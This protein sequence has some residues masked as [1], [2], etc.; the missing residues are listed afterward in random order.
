MAGS[1]TAA[2]VMVVAVAVQASVPLLQEVVAKNSRIPKTAVVFGEQLI[3]LIVGFILSGRQCLQP[4]QYLAFLPSAV[5]YLIANICTFHAVN[6]LGA[7]QFTLLVQLCLISTAVFQRVL[8]GRRRTPLEWL[9][10]FQL[11]LAMC[12]FMHLNQPSDDRGGTKQH[13]ASD[14]APRD[15]V[16]GLLYMAVVIPS[17][18][19]ASVCMEMQLKRKAATPFAAQMHQN[20]F[21]QALFAFSFAA[22]EGLGMAFANCSV[23]VVILVLLLGLRGFLSGL[24]V[25]VL[26]AVVNQI[27]GLFSILISYFVSVF[28]FGEIFKPVVLIQMIVIIISVLLFVLAPKEPISNGISD[29]SKEAHD[30]ILLCDETSN[31]SKQKKVE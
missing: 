13:Q 4:A 29:G 25:K 7:P 24:T 21:F 16:K 22:Y 9:A 10:L 26:D 27:V 15:L 5:C 18:S 28:G 6:A 17:V 19:M 30:V 3:Y 23:M 31:G 11:V 1:L 14:A 20:S 8:R 2:A 12:V